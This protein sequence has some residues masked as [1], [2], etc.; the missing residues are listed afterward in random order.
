[1][2]PVYGGPTRN[3]ASR[4]VVGESSE[5]A[6]HT[7]EEGL[8]LP[9]GFIHRPAGRARPAGVLRVHQDHRD[10]R[11]SCFVTDEGPQLPEG[12]AMQRRPLAATNR[13]PIAD[14][15]EVLQGNRPTGVFRG[16]D[17]GLAD[18]MVGVGGESPFLPRP[19]L[20]QAL[21]CLRAL[22]LELLAQPPVAMAQAVQMPRRVNASI[23]I[24]GDVRHAQIHA[25]GIVKVSRLGVLHFTGRQQEKV[26]SGVLQVA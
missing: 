5:P 2:W 15:R 14:A 16:G 11:Q 13:E 24:H 20:E 25:K 17:E 26:L 6:G 3:V 1:M 8:R 4:D 10:P 7:G 18:A 23:R 21:R 19:L 9:V 22:P 12:P